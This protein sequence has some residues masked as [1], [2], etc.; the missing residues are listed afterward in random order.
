M[1]HLVE[2]FLDLQRQGIVHVAFPAFLQALGG[3]LEQVNHHGFQV[4]ARLLGHYLNSAAS[5]GERAFLPACSVFADAHSTT[6]HSE[7]PGLKPVRLGKIK[8]AFA[9]VP[10]GVQDRFL[11]TLLALLS[12]AFLACVGQASGIARRDLRADA[13][14][15]FV[16]YTGFLVRLRLTFNAVNKSLVLFFAIIRYCLTEG[17]A[18]A[19]LLFPLFIRQFICL[20][21]LDMVASD[22]LVRL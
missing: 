15:E 3:T 17:N 8:P 1:P 14:V 21:P 11:A 19:I 2:C 10:I 9:T 22:V 20:A 12:S 13:V 7:L 16:P 18:V 4:V 5:L 6:L